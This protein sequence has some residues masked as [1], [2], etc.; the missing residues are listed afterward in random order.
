MSATVTAVSI[1][2]RSGMPR[3]N[4]EQGELRVCFGFV[5][6][7]H[8]VGGNRE[9]CLCDDETY[10]QLRAEGLS[11]GGGSFGENITTSGIDFSE[12]R[13]GDRLIFDG[14]A[15]IEITMVRKPCKALTPIDPRLPKIIVG[16]SGWLAK[17][18]TGGIVRSGMPVKHISS[19]TQAIF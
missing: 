12:V 6:N 13:P 8:S 5:G 1:S 15:E 19:Q 3:P 4:V 10:E 9:V 7:K 17:V 2:S 16:R 11:V 14:N 18:I